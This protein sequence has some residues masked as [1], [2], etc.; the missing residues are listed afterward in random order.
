MGHR[1]R[2]HLVIGF[3]TTYAKLPNNVLSS[4]P[5]HGEVH[6][7]QHYVIKFV[8]D[9]RQVCGFQTDRHYVNEILLKVT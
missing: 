9:L 7:I 2:D 8:S 4:N 5:D 6:L 3:A 1:G